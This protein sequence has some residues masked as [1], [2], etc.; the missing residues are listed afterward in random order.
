MPEDAATHN[1]YRIFISYCNEDADLADAIANTIRSALTTHVSVRSMA[2]FS[3]GSVWTTRIDSDLDETDMLILVDTGRMKPNA[4]WVGYEAGFFSKSI[5]QKPQSPKGVPRIMVPINFLGS[6]TPIAY[7]IQ[8]V[9]IPNATIEMEHQ[10]LVPNLSIA[11]LAL[12][13]EQYKF[14]FKSTHSDPLYKLIRDINGFLVQSS[15]ITADVAGSEEFAAK[16]TVWHAAVAAFYHA[17]H[18]KLRKREKK[19]EPVEGKVIVTVDNRRSLE[20]DASPTDGWRVTIKAP[21]NDYFNIEP[22]EREVPWDEFWAEVSVNNNQ[23]L[24]A[25][26]RA[27]IVDLVRST[28]NSGALDKHQKIPVGDGSSSMRAVVT[29]KVEY[30]GG[31]RDVHIYFFTTPKP[32][33]YG[34]PSTSF[35]MRCISIASRYRSLF[36]EPESKYSNAL[37]EQMNLTQ[38]RK[39]L[40]ELIRE[41][42]EIAK[43]CLEIGLDRIENQVLV[44]GIPEGEELKRMGANWANSEQLVRKSAPVLLDAV[45]KLRRTRAV[46]SGDSPEKPQQDFELARK[47]FIAALKE[48]NAAT[49]IINRRFLTGSLQG[50]DRNVNELEERLRREEEAH[51]RS[52][53]N[54]AERLADVGIVEVPDTAS[55]I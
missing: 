34:N 42:D 44:F 29:R 47:T 46:A 21:A 26:W 3:A 55:R 28:R 25:I 27:A 22:D 23:E 43:D 5:K 2:Q 15:F 49:R 19:N 6:K 20:P 41:L 51:Q 48:F 54:G 4:S 9:A 35:F 24:V 45:S 37:V 36:L 18:E 10:D 50:L 53:T 14:K 33:S 40:P 12:N 52:W 39:N 11:D 38:L 17:T 16:E 1:V 31:A 32:V 8:R 30:W 7:N 13:S